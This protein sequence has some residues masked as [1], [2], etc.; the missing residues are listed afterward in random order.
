[1]VAVS[2]LPFCVRNRDKEYDILILVL[3]MRIATIYEYLHERPKTCVNLQHVNM[4]RE[5]GC[6]VSKL[7]IIPDAI[8]SPT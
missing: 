5:C 7:E 3:D 8:R 6:S 2:R 1:M 4:A